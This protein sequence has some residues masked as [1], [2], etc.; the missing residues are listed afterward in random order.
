[1]SRKLSKTSGVGKKCR[2]CLPTANSWLKISAACP[3]IVGEFAVASSSSALFLI[4]FVT[5]LL[6]NTDVPHCG[7]RKQQQSPRGA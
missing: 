3:D 6:R 2:N 5:L 7:F 4:Y 1:M